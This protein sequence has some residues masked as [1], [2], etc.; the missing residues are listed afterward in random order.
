MNRQQFRDWITVRELLEVPP[1]FRALA[2]RKA[3]REPAPP[4]W[5]PEAD[6]WARRRA[7]E[8]RERGIDAGVRRYRRDE[9][10][11]VVYR[12]PKGKEA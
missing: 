6:G 12:V 7:E 5:V 8:L 10:L 11:C 9:P 1:T 4:P 2:G 3:R